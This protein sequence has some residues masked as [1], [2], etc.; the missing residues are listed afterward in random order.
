M[1]SAVYT[2]SLVQVENSF[3][4]L[5]D[6]PRDS[7]PVLRAHGIKGFQIIKSSVPCSTSVLHSP[8]AISYGHCI[9]DNI[10]SY[11]ASI[12]EAD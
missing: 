7:E 6:S 8:I 12:G 4:D 3:T 5:L 10:T 2:V 1:R 11:A 9:E